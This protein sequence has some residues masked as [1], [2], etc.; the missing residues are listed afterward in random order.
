M[1]IT[2]QEQSYTQ[3][4]MPNLQS[5]CLTLRIFKNSKE[6]NKIEFN[7]HQHRWQKIKICQMYIPNLQTYIPEIR[8][9]F[10]VLKLHLSTCTLMVFV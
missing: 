7:S 1:K 3:K 6:W 5:K 9:E 10:Q 4:Y 8:K 2:P